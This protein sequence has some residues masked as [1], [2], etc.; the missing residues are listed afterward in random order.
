MNEKD[1]MNLKKIISEDIIKS[2]R[3]PYTKE[4]MMLACMGAIDRYRKI[5]KNVFVG[6]G[7]Q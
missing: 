3:K 4:T 7:E 1:Y 2:F 6:E 5:N